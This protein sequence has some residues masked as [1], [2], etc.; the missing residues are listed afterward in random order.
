M[1]MATENLRQDIEEL[2]VSWGEALK[3]GNHRVANKKNSAITKIAKEFK[4]DKEIGELVLVPLLKHRNP[5]VR[6]QASVHALDQSIQIEEAEDT[7]INLANDL[8]IHV[9]QLMAQINLEQWNKKKITS[10]SKD[11]PAA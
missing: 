5:S 9:I 10:K 3:I 6:L 8:N 11:K 4:K 1:M 7:L 2:A